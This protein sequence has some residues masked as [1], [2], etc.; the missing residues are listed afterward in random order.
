ATQMRI[1]LAFILSVPLLAQDTAA[2]APTAPPAAGA[3][4]A[5]A[6][7]PPSPTP[8]TDQWLTGSIDFGYRY[9]TDV[10]G[11][12]DSYRSIVNLGSGPKLFGADFTILDPHKKLFD[13]IDV[14]AYNWGGDPYNTAHV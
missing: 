14:R 8:S 2:Q 4:P 12:F 7:T 13:R 10:G 6:A 5:T 3:A 9:R 11:S 1:L